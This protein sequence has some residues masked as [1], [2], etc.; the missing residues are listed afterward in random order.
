[1]KWQQ[2]SSRERYLVLAGLAVLVL[3]GYLVVRF[4]PRHRA[5]TELAKQVDETRGK[6]QS[7]KL[8]AP[9]VQRP[10]DLRRAN[11]QLDQQIAA[12]EASLAPFG[13]VLVPTQNPERLQS[14]KVELSE[15]ARRSAIRI[16][17]SV[18]LDSKELLRGATPV[19]PAPA[20]QA[21]K[22]LPA[23]KVSTPTRS[24][25]SAS[26]LW[27]LAA[28]EDDARPLLKVTMDGTFGSLRRFVLGLN[29]L[30]YKVTVL[31]FEV[32]TDTRGEETLS[33]NPVLKATLVVAL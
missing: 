17:E 19:K 3:A 15:L 24:T 23:P 26:P 21:K 33:G 25:S 12:A 5:L 20:R 11:Q 28:A 13:R 7:T 1:M 27:Q 9:P 29:R 2:N 32:A 30:S 8:P 22:A 31:R 14:L 6:I 16:R 4:V 18:P 10:E